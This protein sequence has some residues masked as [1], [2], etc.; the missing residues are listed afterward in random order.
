MEGMEEIVVG[1]A[2]LYARIRTYFEMEMPERTGLLRL[3]DDKHFTLGKLYSTQ[4]ALEKALRE[5]AWLKTGGYLIIQ[6]TEALTV[7]DVNSGKSIAGKG[8]NEE[9]VLKINL[10][11][12][13]EA[14]RQIRLRNLSGIIIVDFINMDAEENVERLMREFRTCLT[15][16]P[17]Q[18]TLVDITPLNLVEV[19]RKKVHKPLYEQVKK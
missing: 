15:K 6:P 16:D 1:D 2:E 18:A 7:I 3:Y 19:T 11:A 12:A 8:K 4:T 14:A 5:K 10:E 9:G 13:R 17:V